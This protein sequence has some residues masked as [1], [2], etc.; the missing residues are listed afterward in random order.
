MCAKCACSHGFDFGA[1]RTFELGANGRCVYCDHAEGCHPGA[2]PLANGPLG[3][4]RLADVQLEAPISTPK[5]KKE[6][7]QKFPVTSLELWALAALGKCRFGVGTWEKR[8]VRSLQGAIELTAKQREWLC[9]LIYKY[10]RQLKMD[11]DQARAYVE[12]LK[13][14][15]AK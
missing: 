12:R 3:P 10:R 2:G 14:Q 8:F 4:F 13:E 6:P 11:N 7:P 1:C 9:K 5:K 15:T